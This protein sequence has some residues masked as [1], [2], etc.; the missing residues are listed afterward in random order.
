[1]DILSEIVD[2]KKSIIA[3]AKKK[4][5]ISQM[6]LDLQKRNFS[7]A[8]L[9]NHTSNKISIIAEI[10]KGSP[11]KGLITEDFDIK[12]IAKEYENGGATCISILTDER[13]F[14]G[15]NNNIEIAK[16]A[17]NLPILRK[18]FIVDEYQIYESSH[19]GA[20]AIL[21]I[22]S[23]LDAS[24]MKDFENLAESLGLSILVEVHNEKEMEMAL[25]HTK[26]PLVGINNRNLK[27]FSINLQNTINLMK[28]IPH[29]R[30]SVCES[31]IE[32]KNDILKMVNHNCT[33][34]LIG[35]SI[36]QSKD[37]QKFIE[38]LLL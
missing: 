21:L 12:T 10:K 28:M 13:F 14:F 8:I 1:M 4:L 23:I 2:Y 25:M 24:Q 5:L 9:Q 16:S 15:S 18:D 31:G 30:I 3:S 19:I 6:N 33:A 37:R 11:S 22:A 34:F 17:S 26:T 7:N 20:D 36:I 29:N 32:T 35:T 27:N 38:D